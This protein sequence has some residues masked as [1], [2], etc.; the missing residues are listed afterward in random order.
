MTSSIKN[1]IAQVEFLFVQPIV[2]ALIKVPVDCFVLATE[3]NVG[4]IIV[5]PALTALG[6]IIVD[7]GT[8][9]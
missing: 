5:V 9:A 3:F 1:I 7:I 2:F 8:Q 4:Q 6:T